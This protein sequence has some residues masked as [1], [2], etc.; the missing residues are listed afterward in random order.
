MKD[1]ATPNYLMVNGMIVSEV[2]ALAWHA[3]VP[4]FAPFVAASVVSVQLGF[5]PIQYLDL[6]VLPIAALEV[7]LELGP[8]LIGVETLVLAMVEPVL[9][10]AAV[11]V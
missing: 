9:V 8:W 7:W 5:A 2:R 1:R 11:A 4:P 6:V 3:F 10:P